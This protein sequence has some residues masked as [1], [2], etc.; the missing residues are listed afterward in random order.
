MEKYLL[1][2]PNGDISWINA[3]RADLCSSFRQ[4]IGCDWVENVRTVLPNICLVVDECGKI[5]PE[6][7]PHN[8]VASK[9]YYGYLIGADDIAGPAVV[10]AI[11]LVDGEP[12]WVP[13]N[14]REVAMLSLYLGVELPEVEK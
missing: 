11:H 7:Q 9:L 10:C 4:A 14:Q 2:S 5:K 6:P 8:P 12:N 1:I 3:D 13:L